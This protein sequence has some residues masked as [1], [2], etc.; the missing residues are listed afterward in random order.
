[1]FHQGTLLYISDFDFT[2]IN[3]SLSLLH[4]FRNKYLLLLD[5]GDVNIFCCFTTTFKKAPFF[6]S[7]A[8]VGCNKDVHP[9]NIYHFELNKIICNDTSFS[10]PD[11]TFILGNKGQVFDFD[12]PNLYNKYNLT[13]NIN[14]VGKL[15]DDVFINI[16][17]CLCSSKTLEQVQ[18][19]TI[20]QIGDTIVTKQQN[21]K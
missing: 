5:K 2:D 1:M 13:G 19:D 15:N 20:F 14:R 6:V 7:S 4:Q 21:S 16:L 17:H 3:P 18:R 8:K 10:F 9:F 12:L 11:L